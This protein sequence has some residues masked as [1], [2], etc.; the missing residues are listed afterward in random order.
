[1]LSEWQLQSAKNRLSHVVEEAVEKGPQTITVRGK[2]A[3]VVLSIEDYR[4]LVGTG[5][6][7]FDFLARSPLRGVSLDLARS[8]DTGRGVRL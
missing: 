1:M 5:G 8:R 4:R 3:V 7:L 2:P 6:S